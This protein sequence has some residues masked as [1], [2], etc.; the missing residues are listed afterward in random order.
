MVADTT[1]RDMAIASDPSP[2]GQ[3]YFM[4]GD[5]GTGGATHSNSMD[6]YNLKS[7]IVS[8]TNVPLPGPQ[9]LQGGAATWLPNRNSMLVIG[10]LSDN[11]DS[12]VVYLYTPN[13]G[14]SSSSPNNNPPTS[15]SYSSNSN[16]NAG[17][18]TPQNINNNNNNNPYPQNGAGSSSGSSST[19]GNGWA[20]QVCFSSSK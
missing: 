6:I 18:G 14:S 13:T 12:N 2:G 8:E 10:G 4:G 5:A 1:R 11:A 17:Y 16:I 9:N 7:S 20:A 3:I 19:G 15:A